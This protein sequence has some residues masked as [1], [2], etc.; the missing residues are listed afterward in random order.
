MYSVLAD[1]EHAYKSTSPGLS[2]Y[3]D[4]LPVALLPILRLRIIQRAFDNIWE[5]F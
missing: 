5:K 3:E 2:Q 1:Y 4:T